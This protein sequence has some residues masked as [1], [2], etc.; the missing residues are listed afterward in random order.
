M[1]S[2]PNLEYTDQNAANDK[3]STKFNDN[4]QGQGK[5]IDM[6]NAQHLFGPATSDW[7]GESG[8][9]VHSI[10][11]LFRNAEDAQTAMAVP[12]A[13]DANA[14]G[15]HSILSAH[16]A[17]NGFESGNA[18]G[19][20][21]GTDITVNSAGGGTAAWESGPGGGM[22]IN[23]SGSNSSVN[24]NIGE[25]AAW[26]GA[27]TAAGQPVVGFSP[28]GADWGGATTA[29]GQ[30]LVGFS[31]PGSDW[32]GATGGGG[33]IGAGCGAWN[34][35]AGTGGGGGVGAGCGAWNTGAGAGGGAAGGN[36]IQN[37]EAATVQVIANDGGGQESLGS[38][39]FVS[40]NGLIS[41]DYH[42]VQGAQGPV[43]IQT[44]DGQTLTAVPVVTDQANDIAILE[45]V[46]AGANQQF[47]ALQ[48]GTDAQATAVDYAIGHPNGDPNIDVNSGNFAGEAAFGSF[49]VTDNTVADN[50]NRPLEQF[51][52]MGTQPGSSGSPIINSDGVV[53]GMDDLGDGQGNA[54]A[55]I[56]Q[57]I[58]QDVAMAEGLA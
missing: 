56:G 21:G 11:G 22:D 3:V 49:N 7:N 29:A 51:T 54:D 32:G 39:F 25:G 50:P 30:P 13:W 28:P 47:N 31:P 20:G 24:I 6:G 1:S 18:W 19:G 57:A 26:S 40:S 58:A 45:V 12:N 5:E 4:L 15:D 55:T 14:W 37:A 16:S 33:G 35:G 46:G 23:I 34:T 43:Q 44:A 41:T 27:T 42:V 17:I 53:I 9:A 48:L 52:N 38:G 2:S 10:Q 8:T 36:V